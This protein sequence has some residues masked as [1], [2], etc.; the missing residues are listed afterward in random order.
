MFLSDIRNVIEE[1]TRVT[2]NSST[3]IDPVIVSESCNFLDSGTRDFDEYI[4]DHKETYVSISI[5]MNL[6][7]SYYREVWNYRN[8]D[9]ESLND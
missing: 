4:S 3:L 7:K 9:V 2:E 5:N 6:S 1:P 8:A